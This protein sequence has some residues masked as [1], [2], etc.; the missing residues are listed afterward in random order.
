MQNEPDSLRTDTL[1][2]DIE[3]YDEVD[4]YIIYDWMLAAR[5]TDS[6]VRAGREALYTCN[7]A[8]AQRDST[9]NHTS[10]ELANVYHLLELTETQNTKRDK[11]ISLY[12]EQ[13]SQANKNKWIWGGAGVGLG[14][15]LSLIFGK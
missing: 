11:Q 7:L 8:L 3:C 5:Y 2:P 15:L 9:L 6:I 12:D 14:L 10:K 13:L 1:Q 4:I